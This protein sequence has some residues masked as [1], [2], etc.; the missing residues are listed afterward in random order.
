LS[1]AGIEHKWQVRTPWLQRLIWP[2][3]ILAGIALAACVWAAWPVASAPAAPP[4]ATRPAVFG[5]APVPSE[6]EQ[7]PG[8]ERESPEE[9]GAEPLPGAELRP[10]RL[11]VA[12]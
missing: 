4:S 12:G 2:G 6:L 10:A 5:P 1:P 9:L 3:M 11:P 7:S 8:Y